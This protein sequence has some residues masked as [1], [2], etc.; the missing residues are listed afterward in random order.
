MAAGRR[1]RDRP[2][3]SDT[4]DVPAATHRRGSENAATPRAD[5]EA[6][7][8][9]SRW[10]GYLPL[11]KAGFEHRRRS[12]RAGVGEEPY[13]PCAHRAVSNL[14]AWLH[15]THRSASAKHLPVYLDEFTFRHNRRR[16]PMAAFQTLLGLGALH[17]PSTYREITERAA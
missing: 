17:E 8:P 13:L 12:Q 14:K 3:G 5:R 4:C 11:A 9:H 15:G 1:V 6:N 16:T 10:R 2:I 7:S